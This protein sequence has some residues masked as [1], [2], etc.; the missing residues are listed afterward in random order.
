[1]A[2]AADCHFDPLA[3]SGL[4]D[5]RRGPEDGQSFGRDLKI[6]GVLLT[7]YDE[8]TNLTRQVA[9]DLREFFKEEP[10]VTRLTTEDLK[11]K[12]LINFAPQKSAAAAMQ[13]TASAPEDLSGAPTVG[14]SAEAIKPALA[15]TYAR[16]PGFARERMRKVQG[17]TSRRS[18]SGMR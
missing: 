1:M 11:V 17:A 10:P 2:E 15:T 16:S 4:L 18:R 3:H 6:E 7:M 12:V 5:A 14:G 13:P 8:R 9:D